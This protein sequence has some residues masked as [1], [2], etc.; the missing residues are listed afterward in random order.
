MYIHVYWL[1]ILVDGDTFHTFCSEHR[2]LIHLTKITQFIDYIVF[3]S[4]CIVFMATVLTLKKGLVKFQ[5]S[6]LMWTIVTIL[7]VVGQCKFFATNV[8]RGLFW[9]FFP[10]A[11]ISMNDVSAYFCGITLGKRFI[12]SPFLYL[13]PSK[14]WEGFIGA[15]I[16]TIVFSFFF[17]ALLA[18]FH[19]F[20]C[21]PDHLEI[22]PFSMTLTCEPLPVFVP[23]QYILPAWMYTIPI[24]IYPIQLHGLIYGLF[25]SV[26]AP[27]GGFFASAIK[28]AYKL[29]D[30]DSFMPGHG[31][32]MDRMDCQLL[33]ICF[34][35]IH[36]NTFVMPRAYSVH[37][38]LLSA[39]LLTLDEQVLL[40]AMVRSRDEWWGWG[41]ANGRESPGTI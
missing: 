13:S 38:M 20:I 26:V 17:P 32:M 34:T 25:A 23:R 29:K 28:R 10:L 3:I 5:I 31:G 37:T 39:S 40:H 19:W 35:Y 12:K 9:F 30:F 27:F 22:V 33:I 24:T 16:C 36:Y 2:T 21:P 8:L 1:T 7:I 18:K 15:G 6:Q 41:Q 14:T 4:Y 11:T